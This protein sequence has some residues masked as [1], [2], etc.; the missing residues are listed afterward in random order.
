LSLLVANE[1]P[2]I[3]DSCAQLV[4]NYCTWVTEE[5]K[6]VAGAITPVPGGVGPTN[7][8]M[9]LQNTNFINMYVAKS[10]M[11]YCANHLV[12]VCCCLC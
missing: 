6:A 5:C 8:A 3:P 2:C 12:P 1:Q 4:H 7:I 9:L 10:L 11:S